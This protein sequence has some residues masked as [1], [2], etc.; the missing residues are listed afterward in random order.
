LQT[1]RRTDNTCDRRKVSPPSTA[2]TS[3]N[4][5]FCHIWLIAGVN[6]TITLVTCACSLQRRASTPSRSLGSSM[7][8]RSLGGRDPTERSISS[9]PNVCCNGVHGCLIDGDSS[10]ERAPP[11]SAGLQEVQVEWAAISMPTNRSTASIAPPKTS[12]K[13]SYTTPNCVALARQRHRGHI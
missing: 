12:S 2:R 8:R 4:S 6:V 3:Q 13:C 10:G 1:V 5:L 9:G 11:R 7:V